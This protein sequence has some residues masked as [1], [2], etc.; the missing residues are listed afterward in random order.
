MGGGWRQTNPPKQL[1][2]IREKGKGVGRVGGGVGT[3]K[4][5]GKSMRKLCRNYPL[6]N[7]PLVSPPKKRVFFG[8]CK[9]DFQ[10]F[11]ILGSV[12]GGPI[13]NGLVLF[14]V[15]LGEAFLEISFF[16]LFLGGA[17]PALKRA[18]PALKHPNRHLKK[19]KRQVLSG[20]TKRGIHEKVTFS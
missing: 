19:I 2:K 6:A 3:S 8:L 20:R 16:N 14:K 10:V 13:R 18:K 7:Y 1:W 9:R 4:G 12:K 17:K 11:L 15:E 5:T